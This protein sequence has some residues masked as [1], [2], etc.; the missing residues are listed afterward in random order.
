MKWKKIKVVLCAMM[1]LCSC[2]NM[3]SDITDDMIPNLTI[4]NIVPGSGCDVT[5]TDC[6]RG[7]AIQDIY[8]G[9]VEPDVWALGVITEN[10]CDD[11]AD[12]EK[13]VFLRL[14]D[15]DGNLMR[16]MG[17]YELY[18]PP[19]YCFNNLSVWLLAQP[20]AGEYWCSVDNEIWIEL[21]IV[22][23]ED[24]YTQAFVRPGGE[25]PIP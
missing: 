1:F 20:C 2:G 21:L 19:T 8:V 7:L 3:L 18:Y 13:N 14:P 12:V 16:N 24:I 10:G 11:F 22:T 4:M 9:D 6:P 25:L 15:S 23:P 17:M 5:C